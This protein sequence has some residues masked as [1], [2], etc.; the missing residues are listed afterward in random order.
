MNQVALKI[1]AGR[2]RND[3][4]TDHGPHDAIE[5]VPNVYVVAPILNPDENWCKHGSDKET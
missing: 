1:V 2:K 4:F 5:R 3:P